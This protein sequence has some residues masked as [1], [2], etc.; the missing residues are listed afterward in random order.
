MRLVLG[1]NADPQVAGVDK[2]GKHEVDQ[3]VGAAEGNRGLSPVGGQRVQPLALPTGQDD[4]QHVWRF[5]HESN[6]SAAVNR[7]QLILLNTQ[8]DGLSINLF[9]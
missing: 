4:A 7:C 1:E 5:P 6:L 9:R 3:P 2:I 8:A